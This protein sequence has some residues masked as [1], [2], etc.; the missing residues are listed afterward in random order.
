MRNPFGH[1]H[2]II[3]VLDLHLFFFNWDSFHA[4]LNSHYKKHKKVKAYRKSAY[5]KPTDVQMN[6]Y[7]SN[8]YRKDLS[9][10]HFNDEPRVQ[11]KQRVKDQ[12]SCISVFVAYPTNSSSNQE[13]HPRH[14]NS[15]PCKVVWQI[16]KNIEQPQE[17]ETSQNESRLQFSWRQFQQQK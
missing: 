12:Q 17:K 4:R 16:Y 11:E 1:V 13:H 9:W 2:L 6:I 3:A 5:K 15:I 7:Q 8:T 14:E 10:L